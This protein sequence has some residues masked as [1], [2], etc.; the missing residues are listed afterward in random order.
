MAIAHNTDA[1]QVIHHVAAR[2]S[3]LEFIDQDTARE[4]SRLT[5]AIANLFSVVFYQAETGRATAQDFDE[6]IMIVR[7]SLARH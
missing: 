3:V 6:A 4:L 7:A 5:E 2:L 1:Q